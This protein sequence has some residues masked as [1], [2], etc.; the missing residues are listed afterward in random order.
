[1]IKPL[2]AL[3]AFRQVNK[4]LY[5]SFA[6]VIRSRGHVLRRRPEITAQPC[7]LL[8]KETTIDQDRNPQHSHYRALKKKA[9]DFRHTLGMVERAYSSG[10]DKV[11]LDLLS[12]ICQPCIGLNTL[13]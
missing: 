2:T 8:D 7:Q 9:P 4:A 3:T 13:C 6:Q 10:A 12:P 1:M 11:T 5:M